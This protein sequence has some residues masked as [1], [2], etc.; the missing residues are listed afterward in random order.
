MSVVLICIS[1]K[2]VLFL[3]EVRLSVVCGCV[4]L[5]MLKCSVCFCEHGKININALKVLKSKLRLSVSG[6]IHECSAALT[7]P[8]CKTEIFNILSIFS[9]Y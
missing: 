2:V 5:R 9:A 7:I 8:R 3:D 1:K 4:Y 6:M